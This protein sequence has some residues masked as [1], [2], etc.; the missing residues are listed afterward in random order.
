MI[1]GA[2]DLEKDQK[3]KMT[4]RQGMELSDDD[5][6]NEECT[7]RRRQKK[8]KLTKR[9]NEC[10]CGAVS[11]QKRTSKACPFRGWQMAKVMEEVA[12]R[13]NNAGNGTYLI[14]Y[15]RA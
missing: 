12:R 11:H 14:K 15:T 9:K 8:P 4:Y 1:Q 7:S 2:K 13:R 10:W 6:D 5:D 3:K